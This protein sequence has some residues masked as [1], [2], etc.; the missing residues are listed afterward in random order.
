MRVSLRAAIAAACSLIWVP[1][2]AATITFDRGFVDDQQVGPN[3]FDQFGVS[4][5]GQT[6][7][8]IEARGAEPDSTQGFATTATGV[9]DTGATSALDAQLGPFFLRTLGINAGAGSFDAN[10]PVLNV[11]YDRT[12]AEIISGEI[13]DIDSARNGNT[14]AWRVELRDVN[15]DPLA[16]INSPVSLRVDNLDT[17]PAGGFANLDGRAWEFSF[18]D[19]D[20]PGGTIE[21]VA[22]LQIFFTGSKTAG[23]G[24]AFNN[25]ESGVAPVPLPAGGL[26]LLTG[27]AAIAAVRRAR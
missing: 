7:L 20:I 21:D 27:L 2:G 5:G 10:E 18:T 14:E 25:F 11:R 9:A 19:D 6:D 16:S 13:W 3:S 1:A 4:F 15:N 22:S 24:L 12:P 26:L 17:D 23:I 8:F